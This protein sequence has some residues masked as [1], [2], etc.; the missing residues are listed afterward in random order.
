MLPRHETSFSKAT[1]NPSID[2]NAKFLY[3]PIIIETYL[4]DVYI[5]FNIVH[6]KLLL[7][8]VEQININMY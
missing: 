3:A 6:Y 1:N 5:L 4:V 2:L 8:Q 7:T